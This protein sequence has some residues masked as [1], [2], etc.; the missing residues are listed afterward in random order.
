MAVVEEQV[1]PADAPKARSEKSRARRE[2]ARLFFRSPS[3]LIGLFIIGVWVICAI[4]GSHITPKDP[5]DIM[6]QSHL[7]PGSPGYLLGTE[8]GRAHV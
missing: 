7:P 5:F 3:V 1:P 6:G 4:G 8:I 2:K